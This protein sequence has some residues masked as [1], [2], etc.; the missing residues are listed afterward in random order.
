MCIC[1]YPYGYVHCVRVSLL[2]HVIDAALNFQTAL[3]LFATWQLATTAPTPTHG[4]ERV[5][6]IC[7]HICM[8]AMQFAWHET[9]LIV[10][11]C[12][13]D[14]SWINKKKLPPTENAYRFSQLI[15]LHM[16]TQ[17]HYPKLVPLCFLNTFVHSGHLGSKIGQLLEVRDLIVSGF[18]LV[19]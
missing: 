5:T 8:H 6:Y 19:W 11:M 10:H 9:N 7:R 4:S 14:W 16:Y 3:R 18:L 15:Y 2:V 13:M 12:S 17:W 1:T